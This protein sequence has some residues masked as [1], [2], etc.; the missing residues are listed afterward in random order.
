MAVSTTLTVTLR[1]DIGDYLNP[2]FRMPSATL[3]TN[4][5]NIKTFVEDVAT[6]SNANEAAILVNA[7]AILTNANNIETNSTDIGT[8]GVSIGTNV[9][10]IGNNQTAITGKESLKTVVTLN[11]GDSPYS[12]TWNESIE[13]DCTGGPILINVSTAVGQGGQGIEVIK[14][15]AVANDVTIDANS[16]ETINGSLTLTISTL[17]E[18]VHLV[19]NNTNILIR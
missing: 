5:S 10:D 6:L 2:A 9:T 12:A 17:Y 8:N 7:G 14:I 11:S 19:S 15:D 16:S 1:I 18:N 3:D 13:C 4:W